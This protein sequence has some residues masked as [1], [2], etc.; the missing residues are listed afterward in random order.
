MPV[1][2]AKVCAFVVRLAERSRGA[3]TTAAL[4]STIASYV[5]I[6]ATVNHVKEK[7]RIEP[8]MLADLTD[9]YRKAGGRISDAPGTPLR[10]L[11]LAGCK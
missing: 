5:G 1:D 4:E 7:V 8:E 6:L 11:R 9:A 2:Y 10:L 3:V